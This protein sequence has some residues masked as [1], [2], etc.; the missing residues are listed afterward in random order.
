MSDTTTVRTARKALVD[1]AGCVA[2]G[3]CVS[4]CPRNAASIFLG[5]FA[6]IDSSLCVGCGKCVSA[7]PAGTI[8]I[9]EVSR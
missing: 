2:C 5:M 4:S 3:C 9:E 6:K 7:C 8:T 1:K